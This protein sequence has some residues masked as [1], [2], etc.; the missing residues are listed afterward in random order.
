[1]A[2]KDSCVGNVAKL[3]RLK[4]IGG[5]MKRIVAN[6]GIVLVV[7]ISSTRDLSKTILGLLVKDIP[8][9]LPSKDSRRRKNASRVLL[10]PLMTTS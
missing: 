8:L 4:G 1:M 9:I 3:L 10:A 5:L 6:F 7:P 2:P